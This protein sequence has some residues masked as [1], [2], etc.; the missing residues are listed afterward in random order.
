MAR[1]WA[2]LVSML[3]YVPLPHKDIE[4][5]LRDLAHEVFDAVASEPPDVE[6]GVAV[7]E[8]LVK[9]HCVGR[10]SLRCSVDVLCDA[11]LTDERRGRTVGL[12]E[13]VARVL[14]ALACGYA[15]S[16]RWYTVAQ[17]DGLNQALLE[18][19]RKSEQS[20]HAREAECE[21][22][23]TELSLLRNELSHQLL[24][25]VLT[26]LPNRQFFTTRLE[27]VLNMGSP[28]SVYHLEV[29]GLA[30]FATGL[31]RQAC[32][33]LLRIVADRLSGVVP[34][35]QA[36]VARFEAGRFGLLVESEAPAP[37]P[38]PIVE[39][40][41]RALAEPVHVD[42]L[43]VVVSVSVG[44]V[45][46]PPYR[47][48]PVAVLHAADMALRKAKLTGPGRW[49]LLEPDRDGDDRKELRLA[50]TLP[51]AWWTGRLYVAFRRQVRLTDGRPAR[52]DAR[53]RWDH[54]ELA[55]LPHERC[56]TLAER[57]G[58]GERL[59]A[60]LLD[61]AGARLR[62]WPGELPLTVVLPPSL[63]TS[64]DLLAAV[65]RSGLPAER[66][67][68]S[69]PAGLATRVPTAHNLI[70]LANAG[71][72]VAVHD[73]RGEVAVL[74]DV[75]VHAVRLAPAL[76]RRSAERVMG[77]ALRDMIGLVHEAGAVVAVDDICSDSEADWWRDAGADLATGPLFTPPEDLPLP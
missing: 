26:A 57:V 7:G 4:R 65:D 64:P 11:L 39:A 53:L 30:T 51:D 56:V 18:A 60:W 9:M 37:D 22:V 54:A 76:V 12:G 52:L 32:A 15:D 69:V 59:G 68:V 43:A 28:T 48:D 75:P 6:R 38:T 47:D 49:T 40:I 62:S 45:Q 36:M 70:G 29:H 35:A 13:R 8:Q 20:L 67:Q 3:S 74:S 63:A 50:A 77:H 66:L 10:T 2:Y 24:H 42:G 16:V 21:E 72:A 5:R 19:V 71:A 58:F 55:A 17:Q 31:G 46:S 44:V 14:S 23:L 34:G 41:H 1:K 25:D 27:H 61:Q 73:F 33:Q